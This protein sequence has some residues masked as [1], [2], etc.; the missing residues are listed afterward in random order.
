MRLGAPAGYPGAWGRAAPLVGRGGQPLRA[1]AGP[2]PGALRGRGAAPS[3]ERLPG[4]LPALKGV[5]LAEAWAGM[6]DVTPDAV[7]TLGEDA[8]IEGFYI[9]TGLSGHGFGIGPAVG[10]IMADLMDGRR[11]R[12]RPEPLPPDPLLRRQRD[13]PGPL[14][15][16]AVSRKAVLR[17]WSSEAWQRHQLTPP[18]A[19]DASEASR[20]VYSIVPLG[21]KKRMRTRPPVPAGQCSEPGG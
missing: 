5:K 8:R 18:L 17:S 12:P 2:E 4:A 3:K 13:R 14:L 1:H 19:P 15:R 11:A 16:G 9:A 21:R 7:P 6:I 20:S 10:R